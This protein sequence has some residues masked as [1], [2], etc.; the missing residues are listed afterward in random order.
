MHGVLPQH[1]SIDQLRACV[2]AV[3]LPEVDGVWVLLE[4]VWKV[5]EPHR[6]SRGCGTST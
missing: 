4:T 6:P 2:E 1:S 5:R 3:T